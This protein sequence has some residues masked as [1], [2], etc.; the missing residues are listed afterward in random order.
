ML[1]FSGFGSKDQNTFG[2]VLPQ[3]ARILNDFP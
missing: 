2:K 3:E 1:G